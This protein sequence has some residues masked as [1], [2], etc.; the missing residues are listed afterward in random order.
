M[1]GEKKIKKQFEHI[2]KEMNEERIA[3]SNETKYNLQHAFK[4]FWQ[5]M[6]KVLSLF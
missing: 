2:L 1:K 5:M 4:F 6:A 3:I